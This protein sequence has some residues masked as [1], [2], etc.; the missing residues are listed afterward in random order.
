[1]SKQQF[2]KVGI[3]NKYQ[4][5]LEECER[6]WTSWKERRGEISQLR[7]VSKNR[8]DELQTLQASYARAYTFLENHA[9]NCS[10]CQLVARIE[11]RDPENSSGALF[12]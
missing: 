12:L 11:G 7:M 2:I 6:A 3:C 10:L 8:G 9:P 1:M 4:T 5:L